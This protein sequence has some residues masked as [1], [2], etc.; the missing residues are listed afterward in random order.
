MS[1]Y[2]YDASKAIAKDDWPFYALIMAAMRKA[3]TN[4]A[5]VLRRAFPH[6]WEELQARYRAPHGGLLPGERNEY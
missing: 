2:D 5:E 6:V 3:D 1:I 4:N